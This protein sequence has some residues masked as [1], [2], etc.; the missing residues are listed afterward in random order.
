MLWDMRFTCAKG[1]IQNLP[2]FCRLAK[3]RWHTDRDADGQTR[4]MVA[5]TGP[6]AVSKLDIA[7]GVC[8][9]MGT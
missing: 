8:V 7:V 2:D 1:G 6:S 9:V 3:P 5:R 4:L